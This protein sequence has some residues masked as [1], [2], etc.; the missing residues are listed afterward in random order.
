MSSKG[1]RHGGG[2]R[3]K[4]GVLRLRFPLIEVERQE[5]HDVGGQSSSL[6][7]GEKRTSEL[8]G[9]RGREGARSRWNDLRKLEWTGQVLGRWQKGPA[10]SWALG[11]R[12]RDCGRVGPM[13]S[14]SACYQELTDSQ[15][16]HR[17]EG[18]TRL[19]LGASHE[20]WSRVQPQRNP[21]KVGPGGGGRLSGHKRWVLKKVQT[22][23]RT[24]AGGHSQGQSVYVRTGPAGGCPTRVKGA[25]DP[26]G[27]R[28]AVLAH[29]EQGAQGL[30]GG[31]DLLPE[32]Q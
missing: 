18:Q 14:F 2:S 27:M 7:Y 12:G 26:G 17:L 3:G 1:G 28:E 11:N 30:D 6:S 10:R 25:S 31:T 29:P 20:Q 13:V 15:G 16:A 22:W 24:R 23:G 19:T 4:G 8:P 5:S 21:Q 9:G 32:R